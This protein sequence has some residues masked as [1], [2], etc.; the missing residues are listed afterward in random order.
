MNL[1]YKIYKPVYEEKIM[2]N[3]AAITLIALILGVQP[4]AQVEA[5]PDPAMLK[6]WQEMNQ[7][8]M[9]MQAQM[10]L[11][12]QRRNAAYSRMAEETDDST[13]QRRAQL[14]AVA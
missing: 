8:L 1:C 5:A 6:K 7:K 9:Q 3:K 12:L 10:E 14:Y 11:M 4:W 2:K 13:A